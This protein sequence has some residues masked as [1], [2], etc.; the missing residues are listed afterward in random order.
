MEPLGVLDYTAIGVYM[1][2]VLAMGRLLMGR[3]S[4]SLEDYYLGGRRLPWW[5]LGSSGM[6]AWF[7]VTGTMIITSFLFM[8]GPRGLFIEFRGGAVLVLAFMLCFTGKWHRRSGC[9]TGAEWMIFRFGRGRDAESA[10]ALTAFTWLLLTVGMIAYLTRGMGLFLSLFFPFP[11]SICALV[12]IAIAVTY[13]MFSG[14]YGVVVTDLLQTI[15]VFVSA[16]VISAAAFML[17]PDN[18]TL[19][20]LAAQVTT[21]GNWISAF[22]TW[23]VNM[24]KGYEAYES[25]IMFALFY[26]MRNI[27]GGLAMGADPKYFGARSDKE[28]GLVSLMISWLIMIRWPM[29]MGLAVLGIIFVHDSYPDPSALAEVALLVKAH[30][31]SVTAG[32]WHEMT[33]AIINTPG[34]FAPELIAGLQGLLGEGWAGKL[35]MVG[36]HGTID[37]EMILPGVMAV[38]VPAG[39]KGLVLVSCIAAS[40][41]TFDSSLNLSAGFFVRDIYQRFLRPK[42]ENKELIHAS[43][44]ITM[45][46]AALGYLVG[47]FAENINDL[48]GWI[49]MSVGTGMLVPSV[50]RLYWWRMNGWGVAIGL[51]V[52]GT[53]AIIQRILAPG[54]DERIQ[55]ALMFS[56]PLAATI[57]GCMLTKPTDR[58]V[59]EVFFRRTRPW[60]IWGPIRAMLPEEERKSIRTENTYDLISLPFAL[61]YQVT[62][63]M[64]PMMAVIHNWRHFFM[65]L[66][67]FLVACAGMYWFWYRNL[68]RFE[69]GPV[70]PFTM[71]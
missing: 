48:W 60:G 34:N 9:M 7:D 22:P 58:A 42:A 37:P 28:A 13:T 45:S 32:T 67:V 57:I 12:L 43:W 20:D 30:L 26:L 27:I 51:F 16:L 62:L 66:P 14:F 70:K 19:N 31:P 65:I 15:I 39:L 1:V 44:V 55:F 64:L 6:S 11:P 61:V 69:M 41:S 18:T 47:A 24:P 49:I 35:Q 71:D 53:G 25:L 17:I 38:W 63:F 4:N 36:F 10:R 52:G 2:I 46:L 56:L 8:I 5:L 23:H 68:D 54:M 50:L 29:M 21:T 59:L 3:A 40:M 33:A